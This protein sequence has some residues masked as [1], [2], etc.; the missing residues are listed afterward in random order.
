[1]M[2]LRPGNFFP[3]TQ[4]LVLKEDWQ[5]QTYI[6][7]LLKIVS[8][9][10]DMNRQ[11]MVIPNVYFRDKLPVQKGVSTEYTYIQSLASF[12]VNFDQSINY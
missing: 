9:E 12:I 4:Y 5:I 8:T 3:D 6:Y 1:M 10:G 11:S 7:L 2:R